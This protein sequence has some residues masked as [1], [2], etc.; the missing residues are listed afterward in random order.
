[1]RNVVTTAVSGGKLNPVS[2]I[3]DAFGNALGTAI[4]GYLTAPGQQQEALERLQAMA[5]A[6]SRQAEAAAA[7][8]ERQAALEREIS[9]NIDREDAALG[10]AMRQAAFERE[11]SDNIDREDADLGR[12]MRQAAF[13][14]EVSDNI[15]REDADL[16]RAMRQ[17]AFEREVSD[18]ID[19]EDAEMGDAIQRAQRQ[20]EVDR[21]WAQIDRQGSAPSAAVPYLNTVPGIVLVGAPAPTPEPRMIEV[22]WNDPYTG[23][24]MGTQLVPDTSGTS[25]SS[26]NI[27]YPNPLGGSAL[28]WY[29]SI[30]RLNWYQSYNESATARALSAIATAEAEGNPTA[31]W[32]AAYEASQARIDN[33]T[34]FRSMLGYGGQVFSQAVDQSQPPE[35]YEEKYRARAGPAAG[36]YEPAKLM[37]MGASS[38]NWR[39][40]MFAKGV[41]YGLGP[42][43]IGVGAY[44]SY[45]E[46]ANAEDKVEATVTEAGGWIGGAGLGTVG[47]ALAVTGAIALGVSPVGW[48]II[49]VAVVGGVAGGLAG[50]MGGKYTFG[51]AY[52]W[53]FK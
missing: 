53:L 15:D 51:T 50:S 5:E 44:M 2:L 3:S 34:W 10:L 19:R 31:A 30:I 25:G 11:V 45:N 17:A 42:I 8:Y 47:T 7:A 41:K 6:Q 27:P 28:S 21:I 39:V 26:L 38:S 16:G 35:F 29:E 1:V 9:D 23:F 33:R 48:A 49:G 32:L 43:G 22:P 24:Q 14:R 4:G 37:A 13:E 40:D 52:R 20:A 18:N 12:A 36:E 46:I